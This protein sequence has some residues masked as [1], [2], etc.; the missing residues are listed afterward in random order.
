MKINFKYSKRAS[1]QNYKSKK[2][3]EGVKIISLKR[4]LDCG[5]SFSEIMRISK[6][7]PIEFKSFDLKQVNYSEILPGAVKAGHYHLNQDDIW[8]VPPSSRALV[9]LKDLREGSSTYEIVQRLIMGDGHASLLFIPRGVLH[10]VANL[11]QKP[12][13]LIYFTNQ[14]FDPDYADEYRL[15][16]EE[17]GKDF[18]EIARG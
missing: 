1:V 8:F 16:P 6:G 7:I 5:G 11:W 13:S 12:A 10:G 18:W 15:L 14:N 17:F 4:F 2:L 9:G 3:I